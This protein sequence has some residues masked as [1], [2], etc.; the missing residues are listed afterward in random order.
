ML[1]SPL[2]GPDSSNLD[3]SSVEK[4][5]TDEPGFETDFAVL[6]ARFAARG[7]GLPPDLSA[8]LA[9]DIVLNEIVEQACLATGAS[10]AAI[11]L[12]RDQELVCRATSGNTAPELGSRLDA[13][14]GLS[15]ECVRTGQIQVCNDAEIDSGADVVASRQLGVRS[16]IV[17]PLAHGTE[18]VGVLEAFSTRPAAFGERDCH[19]LEALA[20]RVLKNVEHAVQTV[21]SAAESVREPEVAASREPVRE[22]EP[23][24]DQSAS[25]SFADDVP[26]FLAGYD[27]NVGV[28]SRLGPVGGV[29]PGRAVRIVTGIL[30]VAV[31]LS[32]IGMGV[33]ALVRLGWIQSDSTRASGPGAG[34]RQDVR[35]TAAAGNPGPK[36][37]D[38]AA[39]QQGQVA[40][41]G[42]TSIA[43][44]TAS[45]SRN[46]PSSPLPPPGGLVVYDNGK[47]VFRITPGQQAQVQGE[48]AKSAAKAVTPAAPM[49]A[50]SQ[51]KPSMTNPVVQLPEEDAENSLVR[52]VEPDY[53]REARQ[54]GIQGVVVLDVRIARDGSVE[55]VQVISGQPLLVRAAMDAVKQWRFKPRAADGHSV[56]METRVTLS[57]RLPK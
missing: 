44:T 9:L 26:F 13:S 22:G 50:P 8:D 7:G 31:L 51:Q 47:E 53:P 54:H 28:E 10:G 32:A 52:R 2:R 37:S 3:P 48:T 35:S 33:L 41:H 24:S 5:P 6:R 11:A 15:G 17:L 36:V 49:Q 14:Q 55:D 20:Q 1:R 45:Q 43:G 23:D 39:S 30:G 16:V 27:A 56:E 19:T 57:F 34:S 42:A 46:A 38:A 29:R 40:A 18:V 21:P 12:K 4:P 25:P